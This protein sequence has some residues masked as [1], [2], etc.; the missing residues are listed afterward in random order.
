MQTPRLI[1]VEGPDGSGKTTFCL[2]LKAYLGAADV[3]ILKTPPHGLLDI[4]RLAGPPSSLGAFLAFMA[5]NCIVSNAPAATP[6]LVLDRY[7]LSTLVYHFSAIERAG[8]DYAEFCH[9]AGCRG[10]DVTVFLNCAIETLT[11]RLNARSGEEPCEPDESRMLS[12][13]FR[14]CLADRSLQTIL[15]EVIDVPNETP[16]DLV[17]ALCQVKERVAKR[18]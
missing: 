3:A 6:W 15:G 2:R 8:I 12:A 9:A 13:R 14:N 18:Y 10:P 7:L 16:Q 17:L 11:S 1:A 4:A 5:G